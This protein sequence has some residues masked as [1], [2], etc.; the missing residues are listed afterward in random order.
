MIK[1]MTAI[2][3]V[4]TT[5]DSVRAA[6]NIRTYNARHLDIQLRI[7]HGYPLIEERVKEMIGKRLTRGRVEVSIQIR[8]ESE[9]N[10][11]VEVDTARLNAYQSVIPQLEKRFQVSGAIS[12]DFLLNSSGIIKLREPEKDVNEAWPAVEICLKQA[13]DDLEAMRKKEG[14]FIARDFVNRLAYIE[15]CIETVRKA[16]ADLLSSYQDRLKNRIDALTKGM[17]EI[18]TGRIAQEAAFLADR[19]DISE[20]IVRV[21]SHLKQFRDTM[22]APEPAGRKLNFLLQEFTREFNTMGVKAGN[23]DLSHIVVDVKT[24]LEKIRE[25]VQNVE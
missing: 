25:Q 21:D 5:K 13:L 1:S 22:A 20:E 7:S 19:S 23:A 15:T 14:D 10:Y 8:D 2:A 4:E 16:T 12:M 9:P 11:Q 6:A 18:D 24:E 3:A 17:V